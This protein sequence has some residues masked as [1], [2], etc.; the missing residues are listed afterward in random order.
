MNVVSLVGAAGL[1]LMTQN[2]QAAELKVMVTGAA[3]DAFNELAP[4]F[5]RSTGHKISAQFDLPPNFI[6]RIEAGETFDVIILSMD[7]DGLIKQG[8]V[9]A[10]S[11][12][13]LGRTGV[14]VAIHQGVRKPDLAT[15]DA[16]KT[17]LRDAKSV[18]YSGE[19]SSGRYFLSLLDRLG[20]TEIMKAKLRPPGGVGGAAALLSKGEVE[21]AVIGKPPTVGVPNIEWLGWIPGELQSWVVFTGG[22]GAAS[23]EAAAGQA[24]LAFLTA[25]AAVT[26]WKARGLDPVP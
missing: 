17:M 21:I 6:R 20:M 7:V 16:F 23:K 13:I 22:V 4:R 11:R 24:L 19:G 18:T 15:V 26:I 14:G 1:V 10:D 5:E 9:L 8:K 25:P 2:I 3:K 12:T